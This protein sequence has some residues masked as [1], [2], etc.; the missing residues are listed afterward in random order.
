M[1]EKYEKTK[2]SKVK[3]FLHILFEAEI[4]TVPKT[5]EKS[6]PIGREKYGKTFIHVGFLTLIKTGPFEV[7]FF[8]GRVLQFDRPTYFKK[9]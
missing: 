7:S 5:R 8:W 2:H 4:L 3:G 9:N 1:H 6:I